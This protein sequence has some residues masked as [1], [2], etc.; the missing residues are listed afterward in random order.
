[1]PRSKGLQNSYC[2]KSV[3]RLLY[4]AN[5]STINYLSTTDPAMS[6]YLSLSDCLWNAFANA[7]D[8]P[9]QAPEQMWAIR[10]GLARSDPMR[11]EWH[12]VKANKDHVCTRSCAIKRNEFYFQLRSG[13]GCL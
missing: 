9:A 6:Q 7:G 8:Y 3:S 10:E 2:G 5:Q 1:M 13:A 4:A 12:E 11:V